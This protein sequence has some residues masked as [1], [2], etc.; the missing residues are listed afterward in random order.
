M[1]KLA[2]ALMFGLAIFCISLWRGKIEVEEAN[3]KSAYWM[4]PYLFG[5]V[6]ISYLSSFGGIG[7]L[8]FGWDFV[9]VALFST[10]VLH[11]AVS[12]RVDREAEEIDAYIASHSASNQLATE[13]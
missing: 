2:I 12:S 8:P 1:S 9:F 10:V 7:L 11:F 3:N 6:G 13:H 5:L 4:V